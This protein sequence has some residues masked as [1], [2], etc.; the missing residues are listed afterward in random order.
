MLFLLFSLIIDKKIDTVIGIDF[1]TSN[2][3][4]A[5]YING[6]VQFIPNDEGSLNTPSIVSF[7]K[8]GILVGEKAKNEMQNNPLNTIYNIKRLL[9]LRFSDK[10][11]QREIK[12]VPYKIVNKNNHPYVQVELKNETKLFSPEEIAA[13]ILK[14]M[15]R[16]AEKNL[17]F[18][19]EKAVISVPTHS[20]LGLRQ[21][22][23]QLGMIAGFNVQSVIHESVALF[24]RYRIDKNSHKNVL[25]IDFGGGNIDVS[26]I[27][28][29]NDHD[30]DSF[31]F[32]HIENAKR[33]LSTYF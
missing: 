14:E 8:N 3:R 13:L 28:Y 11:L 7:N 2:L 23:N 29:D 5:V 17:G 24:Y 6:K 22:I 1:G 20:S 21:A 33:D 32:N 31:I 15:K 25:L 12:R 18:P 19:V 16:I 10:E 4:V 9:G 27:N 30:T 26:V